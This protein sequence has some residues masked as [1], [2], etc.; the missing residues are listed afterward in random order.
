MEKKPLSLN[1]VAIFNMLGP[2]VLNGLAFFTMPIFTRLLG[3]E[4]YGQ[5]PNY[6]SFLSL[7]AAVVGFQAA[8]AIAPA[9]VRFTQEERDR[10]FSNIMTAALFFAAIIGVL[11]G[12]FLEPI[13]RFTELPSH[14]VVILFLHAT[15]QFIVNF[16]TAKFSYDKQSTRT[17]FVSV[18]LSVV[19]IGLSLLFIYALSFMPRYASYVYGHAIPCLV[20]GMLFAIRFLIKGKSFFDKRYWYFALA[21]CLPLIFHQLSNTLLHQC[22]KIMLKKMTDEATVGV[23]GFAVTFA[24]IINIIWAALNTTFVPFYHDDVKVDNFNSLHKRT[25]NYLFLFSVLTVGFV[26]AMPEVVKL[27]SSSDFWG[28]IYIIPLLVFGLYFVFLY[29]FP[30]NFEFFHCKTK[31]IAIGTCLAAAVNILLNFMLI[32]LW[33]MV[34]AAVATAASYVLLWIFHM[35][36]ARFAIKQQYHFAFR[37]F[38]WYLAA[39]AVA[40]AM[41]YAIADLWYVRWPLFAC[42]G[43]VLLLQIKK[44]KSIF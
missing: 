17:F 39:V 10:V 13:S 6:A 4:G 14:L 2:V 36:F 9:S 5:Y 27:F 23:Y 34:G 19:S 15:G 33:G 41:F 43:V 31:T 11:M 42:L 18:T 20:L 32:P 21:L 35:F 28:S 1:K 16:S 7:M 44:Q 30:V 38:Y 22:D 24:N 37:E 26:Y 25:R 29:S 12:V 40:I 8:G 3:A